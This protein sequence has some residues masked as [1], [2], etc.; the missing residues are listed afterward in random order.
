MP[1]QRTLYNPANP[2][3]PIPIAVDHREGDVAGPSAP[4]A[5]LGPFTPL[6]ASV[7]ADSSAAGSSKPSWYDPNSDR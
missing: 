3:R 2:H 5:Q 7:P 6:A 4:Y 1:T